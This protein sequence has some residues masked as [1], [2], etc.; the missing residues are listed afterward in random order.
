MASSRMKKAVDGARCAFGNARSE[1]DCGQHNE[2]SSPSGVRDCGMAIGRSHVNDP[3]KTLRLAVE[4]LQSSD[5]EAA[6]SLARTKMEIAVSAYPTAA[7]H[8]P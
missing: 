4:T 7:D 5:F 2:R 6:L 1:E 8:E 3:L